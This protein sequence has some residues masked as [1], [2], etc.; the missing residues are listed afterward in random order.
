MHKILLKPPKSVKIP[1]PVLLCLNTPF[2]WFGV[3]SDA[4]ALCSAITCKLQTPATGAE[5]EAGAGAG[6]GGDLRAPPFR[7]DPGT[8]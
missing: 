5:V 6:A 4:A 2:P 8:G 7:H 3:L 1:S